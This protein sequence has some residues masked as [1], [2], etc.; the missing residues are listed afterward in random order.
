MFKK[1]LSKI[2]KKE[3]NKNVE[4]REAVETDREK[5]EKYLNLRNNVLAYTNEDMNLTLT[6]DNQVYIAVFDIPAESNVAGYTTKTLA[7]IHGL[8]THIY[9]NTGDYTVELEKKANSLLP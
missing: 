1:C 7:L 6:E 5:F 3:E 2:F 4:K 9:Y 8:N